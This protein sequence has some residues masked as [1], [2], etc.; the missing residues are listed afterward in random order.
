MRF[1]KALAIAGFSV[2]CVTAVPEEDL[3][4][5]YTLDA[6]PSVANHPALKRVLMRCEHG[7]PG[8]MPYVNVMPV[9]SM[10]VSDTVDAP[11]VA[12]TKDAAKLDADAG[13]SSPDTC[14]D[15]YE[16]TACCGD[17]TCQRSESVFFCPEDCL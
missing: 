5:T 3:A 17:G 8:M 13:I 15:V 12:D 2:A 11:D 6:K 4:T 14:G 10:D 7:C 9:V 16:F 1:V